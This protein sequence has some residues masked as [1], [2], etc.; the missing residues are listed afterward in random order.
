MHGKMA[1][2][3]AIVILQC[4]DTVMETMPSYEDAMAILQDNQQ[5]QKGEKW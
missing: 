3:S 4:C 1:I 5:T 2:L